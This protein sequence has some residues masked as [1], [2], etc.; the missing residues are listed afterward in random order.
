MPSAE[1]RLLR[2][3]QGRPIEDKRRGDSHRNRSGKARAQRDPG[4]VREQRKAS[5]RQSGWFG[6]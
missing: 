2:A 5:S 4:E 3:I 6:K 1:Y